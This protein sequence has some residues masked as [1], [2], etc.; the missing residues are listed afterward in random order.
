LWGG[1]VIRQKVSGE[2]YTE[3]AINGELCSG[4]FTEKASAGKSWRCTRP[5]L[6]LS[7]LLT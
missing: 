2:L 1:C 4:N 3:D 6:T 5:K 7:V